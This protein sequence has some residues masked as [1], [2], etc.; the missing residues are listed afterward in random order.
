MNDHTD[1]HT[2]DERVLLEAEF[3]PSAPLFYTVQASIGYAIMALIGLAL[4]PFSFGISLLGTAVAVGLFFLTRW[5]FQMYYE[6]MSCSLTDRKLLISRGVWNR[7]EQA[8]P[9]DKITDMQMNQSFIMRW[10]EL[11]SI[12]VETA[13]QSNTIGGLNGIVGI[14]DSRAFREAVLNQ[15]DRVVGT[16]DRGVNDIAPASADQTV[17][18]DIRDT[19]KRIEEHLT[20]TDN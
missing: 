15:R 11:E 1:T 18:T 5:Y 13:G 3:L 17:L 10:L 16:A 2:D 12:R 20:R 4:A 7:T 6:R 19:L 8:V 14:R 9:M